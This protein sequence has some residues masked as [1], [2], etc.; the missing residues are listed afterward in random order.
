MIISSLI[1]YIPSKLRNEG[2]AKMPLRRGVIHITGRDTWLNAQKRGMPS[3][4]HLGDNNFL[5][6]GADFSHYAVDPW[7]R[8]AVYAAEDTTSWAQG[9]NAL[10]GKSAVAEMTPPSW[11][12]ATWKSV[13]SISRQTN[14]SRVTDLIFVDDGGANTRAFS[15]E[16]IQYGNQLLLTEAQYYYG[17]R[18]I[19][20]ICRRHGIP[21]APPYVVGHE[22][23]NPWERGS[24]YGGWDPGARGTGNSFCW[25][26]M[27]ASSPRTAAS[28][29]LKSGMAI[30]TPVMPDW[31]KTLPTLKHNS[32]AMPLI[33]LTLTAGII[34]LAIKV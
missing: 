27:L 28:S 22:D 3:L 10:G 31:E 26:C 5:I 1:D 2:A 7:G 15:I 8:I 21:P 13:H 23:V 30:K 34:W 16:F 24:Q 33:A 19:Q 20:N 32:A 18:L 11:W 12:T 4:K 25:N 14:V 9:W 29:A 6:D 17:S